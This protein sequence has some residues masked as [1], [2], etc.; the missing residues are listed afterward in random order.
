MTA[1]GYI[2]DSEEIIKAS[3]SHF[4]HYCTAG[5]KFPERSPLPPALSAKNLPAGRTQLLIFRRIKRIDRHP[6]KSD[7]DSPPES[8]SNTENWLNWN[9]DL[10]HPNKSKDNCDVD[11]E[12]EIELGNSIKASERPEHR[13]VRAAGY[14]PGIIR[15]TRR[16]MKQAEKRLVTVGAMETRRNKGNKNRLDKLGQ[17]NLNRF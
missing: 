13:I 1:V 3:W 10:D 8:T 11:A 7:E 14:G 17:Y 4:Q 9:G 12:S 2:S 15:P 6:S 16:S 5:F